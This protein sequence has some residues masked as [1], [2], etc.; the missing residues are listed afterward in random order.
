MV[1]VPVADPWPPVPPAPA[2]RVL[3]SVFPSLVMVVVPVGD[4]AAPA[5]PLVA[6]P[7]A[8]PV[9]PPLLPVPVPAVR[10]DVAIRDDAP[11]PDWPAATLAQ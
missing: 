11:E 7:E 5:A 6:E 8:A 2:Y 9:A 1:V 4:P 3:V 10:A